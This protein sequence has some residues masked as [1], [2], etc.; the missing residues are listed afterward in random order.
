MTLTLQVQ[1]VTIYE[2][3]GYVEAAR[4]TD[5]KL[6]VRKRIDDRSWVVTSGSGKR[7]Q[8]LRLD[9]HRD[10]SATMWGTKVKY[11]VL[12]IMGGYLEGFSE[13]FR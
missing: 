7:K 11:D 12:A 4:V 5:K 9:L 1:R 10:N 3:T 6:D 2:H 13:R 8:H